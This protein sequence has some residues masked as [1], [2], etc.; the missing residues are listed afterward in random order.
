M[1]ELHRLL[2]E[3]AEGRLSPDQAAHLLDDEVPARTPAEGSVAND[4][5]PHSPT[6]AAAASSPASGP[7]TRLALRVSARGVRLIADPTVATVHVEGGPH[8]I[9]QDGS[10]LRVEADTLPPADDG[11]ESYSLTE[12]S[13]QWRRWLNR[14]GVANTVIVRA[15][16][17]LPVEVAVDAGALDVTGWRAPLTFSVNA[18]AVKA[19]DCHG[20]VDG[21]IRAGS[22]KLTVLLPAGQSR[23]RAEAGSIDLRLIPGSN[24]TIHA[25]AELG[26]IAV[27]DS[28]GGAKVAGNGRAET[29]CGDGTGNLDLFVTMGSAKVLTA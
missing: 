8:R 10:T 20:L 9:R 24:V 27:A 26:S 18:G 13:S 29:V 19:T 5:E 23:L 6:S 25:R 12:S 11:D 7:V 3:V 28:L 14:R 1:S 22:A 15:N 4:A 16:P 17:T 2:Q 21:V